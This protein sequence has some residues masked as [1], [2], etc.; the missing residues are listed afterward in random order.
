MKYMIGL[1]YI[2]AGVPRLL[3]LCRSHVSN[4]DVMLCTIFVGTDSLTSRVSNFG[5]P[6][7]WQYPCHQ[8]HHVDEANRL[9]FSPKQVGD[10]LITG[11]MVA[12]GH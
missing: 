6:S 5:K 2:D 1:P 7:S 4:N 8:R 3:E 10:F 11:V 12:C 9:V